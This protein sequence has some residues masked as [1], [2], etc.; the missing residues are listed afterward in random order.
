MIRYVIIALFLVLAFS[1]TA[2]AVYSITSTSTYN[3]PNQAT[4]D[5]TTGTNE[6]LTISPNGTGFVDIQKAQVNTSA[7]NAGRV[8]FQDYVGIHPSYNLATN[9]IQTHN[10]S[11]PLNIFAYTSQVGGNLILSSF[12]NAPGERGVTIG[13]WSGNGTAENVAIC[14]LDNNFVEQSCQLIAYGSGIVRAERL[15]TKTACVAGSGDAACSA[16]PAG[17]FVI[18]ATDTNTVVST[19]AVS[20]NSQILVSQDS[21]LGTLLGVT[22][23]TVTF[24]GKVTARTAS[25]SFTYTVDVAPV[26]DPGCYSYFIIN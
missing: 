5:I 10:G 3:I 26:T 7:N 20:A 12:A 9:A 8:Q 24:S 16:A 15:G 19:T 6:D 22:C 13:V 18:D 14:T 2:V 11:L 17:S 4:V 21:S 25:T 1:G 23:N